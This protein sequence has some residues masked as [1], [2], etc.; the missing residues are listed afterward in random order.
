MNRFDY[1]NEINT[2]FTI[3]N[4]TLLINLS[5]KFHFQSWFPS[6]EISRFANGENYRGN[7]NRH[8]STIAI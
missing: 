5:G 8:D 2:E 1:Q 7:G 3:N 4:M 6:S